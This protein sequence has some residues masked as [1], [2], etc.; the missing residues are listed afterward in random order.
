MLVQKTATTLPVV[1]IIGFML[2]PS[3]LNI[4]PIY[5]LIGIIII[6]ILSLKLKVKYWVNV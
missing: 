2:L 4:N 6:F 1:F 3:L 5:F